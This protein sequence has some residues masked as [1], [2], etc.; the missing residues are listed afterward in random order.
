MLD[1]LDIR[2]LWAQRD[3][4]PPGWWSHPLLVNDHWRLYQN[5]APGGW[6]KNRDQ[7]LPL[8]AREVYLIPSGL[9]LSSDNDAPL[10]QFFV[11]FD[12]RG[13]PP[14]VFQEMFPG[15]VLIPNAPD[16]GKTVFELGGRVE[17]TGC[18]D[19]GSQC[20]LKGLLYQAFGHYFNSLPPDMLERCWIRVS[21]LKPVLPA[22][23]HIHEHLGQAITNDAMAALCSMSE[24]Y[25]IRRFREA[26]GVAPAKYVLKRRVA[27]AA[28]RLLFT[29][30]T[31][32]RIAEETGFGDRFYFSRVFARE[33]GRPP[34]AYRRGPR[35]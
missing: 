32:D 26:V 29:D 20:L 30:D 9:E 4:L 21:A 13:L 11:H 1:D 24:D 31:I 10:R 23:S 27:L 12:L 6:L 19:F 2:L 7:V 18:A 15:P 8:E 14:I 35:T 28:Q 34:A 22:I 25:F 33:T 3:N 16:F 5:D 17:Q